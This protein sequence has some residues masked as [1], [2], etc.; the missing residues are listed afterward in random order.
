MAMCGQTSQ[1]RP[2]YSAMRFLVLEE[3]GR[4]DAL[5]VSRA[6]GIEQQDWSQISPMSDV[7]TTAELSDG[8]EED[9]T[10]M[11]IAAIMSGKESDLLAGH[12][13]WGSGLLPGSWSW[14]KVVE[15]YPGIEERVIEYF[16]L[17]H[18]FVEQATSDGGICGEEED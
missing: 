16:A 5:R 11:A 12:T 17:M 13:P 3:Q 18:L 10:L 7:Y 15:L 4:R 1:I 2:R 9:A 8:R 6:T 14:E